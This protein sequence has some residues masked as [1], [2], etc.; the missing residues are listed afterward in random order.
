MSGSR[1][2]VE[3]CFVSN[4]QFSHKYV[5]PKYFFFTTLLSLFVILILR[6]IVKMMIQVDLQ[7]F[8]DILL[9]TYFIDKRI[10]M[11]NVKYLKHFKLFYQNFSLFAQKLIGRPRPSTGFKNSNMMNESNENKI[12]FVAKIF[13]IYLSQKLYDNQ[14]STFFE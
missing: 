8:I 6:I 7:R 1:W 5:F 11:P 14:K 2:W 13:S 9:L 4:L 3:C 10:F 12:I